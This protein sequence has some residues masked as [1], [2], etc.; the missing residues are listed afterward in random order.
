MNTV[1]KRTI[2][3]L[4]L[5]IAGLFSV[6]SQAQLQIPN[7]TYRNGPAYYLNADG[8]PPGRFDVKLNGNHVSVLDTVRKINYSFDLSSRQEQPFPEALINSIRSRI[9][10]GPIRKMI[11]KL[12]VSDIRVTPRQLVADINVYLA[13]PGSSTTARV[14]IEV[15]LQV[16]SAGKTELYAAGSPNYDMYQ[17]DLTVLKVVLGSDANVSQINITGASRVFDNM[18]LGLANLMIRTI[19]ARVVNYSAVT[20]IT[21]MR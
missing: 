2:T 14:E 10:M 19:P 16:E 13:V 5:T 3:S 18:V 21:K 8:T 6:A 7:G 4:A 15:T 11:Q 17:G 9:K 1:T 12:T 20:N